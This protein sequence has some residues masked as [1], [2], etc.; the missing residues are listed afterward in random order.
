MN[1]TQS[2]LR[3]TTIT[4]L[5]KRQLPTTLSILTFHTTRFVPHVPDRIKGGEWKKKV[6]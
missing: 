5:Q 3:A 2:Y 1:K 6:Q 4:N